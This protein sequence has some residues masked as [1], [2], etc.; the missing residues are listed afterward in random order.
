MKRTYAILSSLLCI[1]LLLTNCS[2]KPE[3]IK[4]SDLK[5]PCDYLDASE[6]IID[7]INEI[8]SKESSISTD[9]KE[10]IKSLMNKLEDVGEAADK[11]YTKKELMECEGFNRL[12]EKAEK[13]ADILRNLKKNEDLSTDS[14]TV[15]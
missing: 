3:Q 2:Q 13:T 12:K 8:S 9:N 11:K 1:T 10:K 6:N 14:V 5:T 7:E 4:L 15:E